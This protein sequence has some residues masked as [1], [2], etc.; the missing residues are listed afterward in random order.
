MKN[1]H[2]TKKIATM[3]YVPTRNVPNCLQSLRLIVPCVST[4]KT[5]YN[6]CGDENTRSMFDMMYDIKVRDLFQSPGLYESMW[7]CVRVYL[8]KQCQAL[9][10]KQCTFNLIQHVCPSVLYNLKTFFAI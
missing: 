3:L 4:Y 2:V 1:V 6:K 9:S 8:G 7:I 10:C 5:N